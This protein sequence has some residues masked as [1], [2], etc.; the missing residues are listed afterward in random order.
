[1][2]MINQVGGTQAVM[3]DTVWVEK[4]QKMVNANEVPKGMK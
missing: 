1:M 3:M 2:L 4:I